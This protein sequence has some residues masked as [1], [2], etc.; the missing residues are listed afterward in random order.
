[1]G[2]A[3][4]DRPNTGARITRGNSANGA[5]LIRGPEDGENK[6]QWRKWRVGAETCRN[7]ELNAGRQNDPAPMS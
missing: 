2:A 6:K 1:V 4:Y 5:L 3:E 7:R